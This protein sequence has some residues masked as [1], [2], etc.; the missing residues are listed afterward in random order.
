MEPLAAT[1]NDS[2]DSIGQ[3]AESQNQK[4]YIVQESDDKDYY[5]I[6]P[7]GNTNLKSKIIP[8]PPDL[9]LD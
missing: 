3:D 4:D 5:V 9:F 8:M 7:N 2:D 1:N 6:I